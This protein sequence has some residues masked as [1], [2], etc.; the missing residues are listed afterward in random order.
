M[1]QITTIP[2]IR[3]LTAEEIETVSGG[4]LG[5]SG[6]SLSGLICRIEQ[7]ISCIFSQIFSCGKSSTPV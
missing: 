7:T 2:E 3:E 1:Q 4:L 6:G 5:N